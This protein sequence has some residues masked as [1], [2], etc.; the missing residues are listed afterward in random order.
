MPTPAAV[1]SRLSRRPLFAT[2]ELVENGDGSPVLPGPIP[3]AGGDVRITER[4]PEV[5]L[6]RGEEEAI[7]CFPGPRSP[8]R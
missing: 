5:L 6:G 2:V 8:L 7:V 3:L 1:A 4:G